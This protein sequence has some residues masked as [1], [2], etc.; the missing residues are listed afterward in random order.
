MPPPTDRSQQIERMLNALE[1][2]SHSLTKWEEDFL[3]SL[4]E[5]FHS[6]GTLSD[7]QFEIL[8][9]IYAEKTA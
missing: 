3:A 8:D 1:S 9:N 7:R 6:R 2:P 4:S 5:Q